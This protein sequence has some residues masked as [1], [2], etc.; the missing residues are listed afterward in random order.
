[1]RLLII[2]DSLRLQE[3][4]CDGL[5]RAGYAVDV[6]GEGRKGLIFAQ[7]GFYDA[8]VLDLM[9]PDLDGLEVLNQLRASGSEAHVLILTARHSLEERIKGLK[10]GADDYLA[11]PFSFDE[12]LARLEAMVRRSYPS[13]APRLVIG[14]LVLEMDTRRVFVQETEVILSKREFRVLEY[15]ARRRDQIV[16]RIDIENHIYNEDQFPQSNTV[17]SAISTIR[18]KLREAGAA[19]AAENLIQTRHGLGYCLGVP[20]T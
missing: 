6:V 17:E 16:S 9:L 11:K 13:K 8:I 4:L 7:R 15:L 10:L 20:R 14:P 18:R 5:T 12:L 1:M 19:A 3:S 2:E